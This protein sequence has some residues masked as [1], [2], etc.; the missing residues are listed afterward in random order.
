M[1]SSLWSPSSRGDGVAG[2]D[3]W[4]YLSAGISVFLFYFSSARA[5]SWMRVIDT[6]RVVDGTRRLYKWMET[7]IYANSR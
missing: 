6:G 5:S 3:G 4:S 7:G 1:L 2:D